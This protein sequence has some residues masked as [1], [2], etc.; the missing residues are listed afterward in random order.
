MS[1]PL[2][3]DG[4]SAITREIRE[5]FRVRELKRMEKYKA[6]I[7]YLSEQNTS[8]TSLASNLVQNLIDE[9]KALREKVEELSKSK[10]LLEENPAPKKSRWF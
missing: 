4:E 3:P 5:Y 9:N 8:L 6:G 1:K 2:T 7:K 10:K